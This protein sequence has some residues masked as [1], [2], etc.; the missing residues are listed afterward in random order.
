MVRQSNMWKEIRLSKG[1]TLAQIAKEIGC[2]RQMVS[3]ME[4]GKKRKSLK[5]Q[6]YILELRGNEIDLINANY[7]KER[8]EEGEK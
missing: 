4:Q 3:Y 2:T 6:I 8:L 5:Y 7:L 1:I